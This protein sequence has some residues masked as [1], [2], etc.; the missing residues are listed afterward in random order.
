ARRPLQ[1]EPGQGQLVYGQQLRR[2]L[3]PQALQL[4]LDLPPRVAGGDVTPLVAQLL[5]ARERELDLDAAVPEIEPRRYDGEALLRDRRGEAL[6]LPPVEEELARP[7]GVVVGAV[8]L[9]VL[10]HVEVDEPRLTVT[11][12]CVRLLQRRIALAQR[13]DLR[14]GEH[15][16]RLHAVRAGGAV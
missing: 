4:A 7:V 15:D 11:H 5:A 13:L 6:D 8:P 14:A 2:Q 3:A 9:R 12:L 1:R 16:A 10:G